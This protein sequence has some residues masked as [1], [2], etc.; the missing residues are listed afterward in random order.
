MAQLGGRMHYAVPRIFHEA[1]ILKYLVTDLHFRSPFWSRLKPALEHY[2]IE[3]LPAAKVKSTNL[4]SLVSR[5]KR[6]RSRDFPLYVDTCIQ[7]AHRLAN[8]VRSIHQIYNFGSVYG[9]DT[10]SKEI[11]EIEGLHSRVMEQCIA[12]RT[13]IIDFESLAAKRGWVDFDKR[14]LS[15]LRR[16]QERE[17]AE[18]EL[19]T[20]IVV[21]SQYVRDE[22]ERIR[23]DLLSKIKIVP[24]GFSRPASETEAETPLAK[25]GSARFTVLFA[26]TVSFRKGISDLLEAARRCPKIS[27]RVAGGMEARVKE[28]MSFGSNVELLGRLPFS[29]LKKE[30][31]QADVFCLPS[32]LEGSATVIYEAMSYG[33]PIV[34]TPTSGS[35]VQHEGEGLLVTAGNVDA[36]AEAVHMLSEDTARRARLAKNSL[37]RSKHFTVEQYG[38]RLLEAIGI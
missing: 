20:S 3:A 14:R 23:P 37:A 13:S 34:T 15:A 25:D 10:A 38:K 36:L 1:G 21:P 5:A 35:V 19:A 2:R 6:K 22:I 11:F 24:Y 33:L 27:F 12:P 8:R 30:F 32:Y 18:W 26:G 9:F 7:E 16:L 31:R 29:E 4:K 28:R 17:Q